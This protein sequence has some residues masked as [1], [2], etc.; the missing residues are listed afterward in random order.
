VNTVDLAIAPP[1]GIS[2]WDIS[3]PFSAVRQAHTDCM[4][5]L[6]VTK[7]PDAAKRGNDDARRSTV[8][9]PSR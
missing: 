3:I 9:Q 2:R 1:L 5:E 7:S 4:S 8:F 6:D